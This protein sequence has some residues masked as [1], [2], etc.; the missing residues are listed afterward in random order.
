MKKMMKVGAYLDNVY[1]DE[2][3]AGVG[4]GTAIIQPL[5]P[6]TAAGTGVDTVVVEP[7]LRSRLEAFSSRC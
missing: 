7:S 6:P 5:S 4:V 2:L 1:V 3:A